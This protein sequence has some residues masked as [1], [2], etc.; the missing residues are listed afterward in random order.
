MHV[1]VK[2]I[3][4][5]KARHF[6]RIPPD[7]TF[8][9]PGEMVV[10]QADGNPAVISTS[11]SHLMIAHTG[12]GAVVGTALY[13]FEARG[14]LLRSVRMSIQMYHPGREIEFINQGVKAGLRHIWAAVPIDEFLAR[15]QASTEERNFIL[16]RRRN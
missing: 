2:V 5:E 12:D 9:E 15:A 4:A 3:S 13:E 10:M 6:R 14:I 16:F 1:S 11:K 8:L 7:G